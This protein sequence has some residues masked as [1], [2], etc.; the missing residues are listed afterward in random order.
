MLS[1]LACDQKANSPTTSTTP[2]AAN[3]QAVPAKKV[4]A[5]KTAEDLFGDLPEMPDIFAVKKQPALK[6]SLFD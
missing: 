1:G 2:A 5:T 4:D 6:K 3:T